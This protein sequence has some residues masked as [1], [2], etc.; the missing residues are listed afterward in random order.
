MT[1]EP[2][3]HLSIVQTIG[4]I[5]TISC[6]IATL[7]ALVVAVSKLVFGIQF[8][9]DQ[10]SV[11]V[12]AVNKRVDNTEVKLEDTK[13]VTGTHKRDTVKMEGQIAYIFEEQKKMATKE[14]VDNLRATIEA[15]FKRIESKGKT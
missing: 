12:I 11:E 4:L 14:S 3:V 9:V 5:V 1:A 15:G 7:L 8:K 6:G 13:E 2:T 10:V